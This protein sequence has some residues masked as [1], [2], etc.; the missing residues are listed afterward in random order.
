M[1]AY[2]SIEE[3]VKY[4][5]KKTLKDFETVLNRS[6]PKSQKITNKNTIDK[7]IT[8]QKETTK[9]SEENLSDFLLKCINEEKLFPK[10]VQHNISAI[11]TD[12]LPIT[13]KIVQNPIQN[14]ATVADSIGK[15]PIAILQTP[16]F[17]KHVLDMQPNA[18]DYYP[19]V[20]EFE[21][22]LCELTIPPK[23]GIIL[24]NCLHNFCLTCLEDLILNNDSAEVRC[25][26]NE[27]ECD[28][29]L[30]DSEI[31]ALVTEEGYELHLERSLVPFGLFIKKPTPKPVEKSEYE[32]LLTLE[33]GEL[34][35]SYEDFECPICL[36]PY[37]IGE[38]FML[39]ECLHVF[40][41]QCLSYTITNSDVPQIKCPYMDDD[42]SC[43]QFLQDR[44][45]RSAITKEE[46]EKYLTMG[47]KMAEN[48]IKESYHCL[49]V[50]CDGWWINEEEANAVQCPVC[51]IQNC[52]NCNVSRM[53]YLCT[54]F[55]LNVFFRQFILI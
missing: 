8:P 49:T 9:K 17:E 6:Q 51:G 21:C 20:N 3:Y 32:E 50:D 12:K 40:C 37:G 24:Q 26:F 2:T 25:P 1:K 18:P 29:N 55:F 34:I 31:K 7:F 35:E 53:R 38:G 16:V 48:L 4:F 47:L 23:K 43:D 54:T 41:K 44:E 22:T 52:L 46:Y 13:A 10:A 14:L 5:D 28:E 19:N 36:A 15:K 33:E 30:L 42:Y 39:R 27:Y 45:I 11:K